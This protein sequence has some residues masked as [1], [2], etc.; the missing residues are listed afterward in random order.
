MS[1]ASNLGYGNIKPFSNVNSNY[2]NLHS[3]NDPAM[4][5]SRQIPGCPGIHG[6]QSNVLTANGIFTGGRRKKQNK[7]NN[8][9]KLYKMSK[10]KK[11]TMRR[12]KTSK[13][14]RHKKQHKT[15]RKRY[16]MRGGYGQYQNNA[17]ITPSY[18]IGG[19]LSPY[20]SALANRPPMHVLSNNTNCVDNYNHYTNTGFS[21]RN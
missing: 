18:S 17:P 19:N 11:R 10:S 15:M 13:K 9:S 21:S 16:R 5:N 7:I 1:F 6:T 14:R 12:H 20:D 8:I 4:L 2:V 3:A